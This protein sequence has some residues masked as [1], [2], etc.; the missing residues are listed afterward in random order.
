[1]SRLVDRLAD[2][3]G[4]TISSIQDRLVGHRYTGQVRARPT[5]IEIIERA[6]YRW[7]LGQAQHADGQYTRTGTVAVRMH[8]WDIASFPQTARSDLGRLGRLGVAGDRPATGPFLA[9]HNEQ[10]TD[11]EAGFGA[12]FGHG[13]VPL[14]ITV[15]PEGGPPAEQLS[16]GRW[17]LVEKTTYRLRPPDTVPIQ[18]EVEVHEHPRFKRHGLALVYRIAVHLPDS[19]E[20]APPPPRLDRL[21]VAWPSHVVAEDTIEALWLPADDDAVTLDVHFDATRGEVVCDAFGGGWS[22]GEPVADDTTTYEIEIAMILS[23]PL[24]LA[25]ESVST[26]RLTTVVDDYL[27][28]GLEAEVFGADGSKLRPDPPVR[29]RTVLEADV[30]L[31]MSEAMASRTVVQQHQLKFRGIQLTEE[32]IERI[33][34]SLQACDY[35]DASP[36]RRRPAE[37]RAWFECLKKVAGREVTLRVSIE[38]TERQ[39]RRTDVSAGG[40]RLREYITA[41]DLTIDLEGEVEGDHILL[42]SELNDVHF[43]LRRSLYSFVEA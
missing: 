17:D 40:P 30:T 8:G 11:I 37:L 26:V 38:G 13:S 12:R 21:S 2:A 7:T 1:M 27:L 28:S 31:D 32:V 25:D 14:Q 34:S 39:V 3:Y 5:E 33:Q 6:G 41:G 43:E 29:K 9:F 20:G 16:T 4:Q 19:G 22:I 10:R 23:R 36:R 35:P 42:A 18:C 24:Q 15:D